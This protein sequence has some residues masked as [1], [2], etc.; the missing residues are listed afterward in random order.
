MGWARSVDERQHVNNPVET[1]SRAIKTALTIGLT[2]SFFFSVAQQFHST[3]LPTDKKP[4]ESHERTS[5]CS[6]N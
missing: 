1:Q 6:G 2:V 4:R 3:L 5:L